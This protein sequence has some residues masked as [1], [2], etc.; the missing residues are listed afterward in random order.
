[1]FTDLADGEY[2]FRVRAID[3]EGE[4]SVWAERTFTVAFEP[5]PL[6]DLIV[7]NLSINPTSPKEG[8][9]VTIEFEV[10]NQGDGLAATFDWR[11]DVNG[12]ETDTGTIASLEAGESSNVSTEIQNIT[13]GSYTIIATA[14]VGEQVAESNEDNN[15]AS[16]T[17][18]VSEELVP[19]LDVSPTTVDVASNAG[20]AT[21]Q[22]KNEG[23]GTLDWS[24]DT[25]DSWLSFE[26]A[27]TGTGAGTVQVS[28]A[29]NTSKSSRTGTVTIS[30]ANAD[31]SPVSVTVQQAPPEVETIKVTYSEGWNLISI[32]EEISDQTIDNYFTN[33]TESSPFE[34]AG[35][36]EE[37][38]VNHVPVS[39]KGYWLK[40]SEEEQVE[41]AGNLL[42][43]LTLNLEEGWNLVGSIG[44]PLSIP[45]EIQDSGGIIEKSTV[46]EI[47]YDEGS[48]T[49]ELMEATEMLPGMGY[50]IK[51]TSAGQIILS[52]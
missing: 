39:G 52:K 1:V 38:D 17:F 12:N 21:F 22:I 50:F 29:Q 20:I 27:A 34:F 41:F 18:S 24:A 16:E 35:Q 3:N 9:T 33:F 45:T 10:F 14:D 2:L 28:Y 49:Y 19:V 40:L 43:S 25:D 26:G 32:P 8:D 37:I 46:W 42:V 36:Y 23:E 15:E 51:A 48:G 30:S 7:S 47:I 6:P 31:N 13:S 11:L 5:P 4:T 44:E